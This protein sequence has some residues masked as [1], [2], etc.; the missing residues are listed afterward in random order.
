MENERL[1][2]VKAGEQ[3]RAFVSDFRMPRAVR[4][5]WIIPAE[6]KHKAGS[7]LK[8]QKAFDRADRPVIGKAY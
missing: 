6:E 5:R 3:L 2:L 1:T 7:D 4:E 8:T